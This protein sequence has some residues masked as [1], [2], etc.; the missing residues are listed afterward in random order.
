ML[1]KLSP[2]AG[3]IT[4]DL[5]AV[6]L[7]A[8][9]VTDALNV[10]FRDG[11]A[12]LFLSKSAAYGTPP[13]APITV[14]PVHSV[15]TRYW[16]VL[17]QQ[18]AYCVTGAPPTWTNITRQSG[19]VDVDYNADLATCWNGGV[20]NGVPILNNGEDVPQMWAPAAP[21][22][23]LQPLTAW[24]SNCQ[25]RVMRP[26]G[27][28]MFAFD[29][30]KA[31]QRFPHR[32]KWSHPA[33]PGTVP[34]SWNE[35]DPTKD[36]GEFDL[37]GSGHIID[38]LPLRQSLVI[39]AEHSTHICNLVGAP[40]IFSFQQLFNTGALSSDCVVEVEG[41]H[42]VM[43]SSD[44]IRHDGG[45]VTSILEKRLRRWLFE[46]IE[47][48]MVDRCF[49][50]KAPYFNEVWICFPERGQDSCTKAVVYNY[51]D[52]TATIRELPGVSG[53]SVGLV[54]QS[55]ADTFDQQTASFNSYAV[56]FDQG[57]FGAQLERTLFCSPGTAQLQLM[58][59]TPME[60]AAI[61]VGH[62]ERTG[63]AFD[64]PNQVK[65]V[66]RVRPRLM[67]PT[68][69]V[70]TFRVGGQMDPYGDIEWSAPVT[71]TVGQDSSVDAFA[72]GRFLAYRIEST[73]AYGWRLEGLDFEFIPR[74]GW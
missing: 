46:N 48:T 68:G 47:T 39:Y 24:P 33:D 66:T 63:L 52:G 5:S 59:S 38:A 17:G 16:L 45:S 50:T 18:K 41:S 11:M 40:Y 1:Y 53:A 4:K 43:T 8:G 31:G 58:D 73:L 3:G 71:F 56:A 29:I 61:V 64:A 49:L 60:A 27:N 28:H 22:T 30:T 35:A 37:P 36:A 7:P 44:V 62:M 6:E 34:V 70:L 69:S 13:L 26:F 42:I 54:E 14:L 23:R 55:D 15:L 72:S 25:A 9:A 57:E 2:F 19:G 74:G 21:G 65:T 20:L 51:K 32:V 12:E 10:R 67:A